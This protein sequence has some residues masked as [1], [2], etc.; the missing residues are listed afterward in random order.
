M[1]R[2]PD[3]IVADIAAAVAKGL[4]ALEEWRNESLRAT[5]AE[6]EERYQ[7]ALV[8]I[9]QILQDARAPQVSGEPEIHRVERRGTEAAPAASEQAPVPEE[10]V[11]APQPPQAA[12]AAEQARE[13]TPPQPREEAPAER[14]V[15]PAA[16]AM[17]RE[18]QAPR[19]APAAEEAHEAAQE[20]RTAA[21]KAQSAEQEAKAD[22]SVGM[23]LLNRFKLW[24]DRQR[25]GRSS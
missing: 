4:E 2:D 12:P 22:C 1:P 16:R 24:L 9:N 20:A 18:R 8:R 25:Q 15:T 21:L 19:A 11:A 17:Q 13:E 6:I 7:R 5:S 23:R 10:R 14:P 3:E